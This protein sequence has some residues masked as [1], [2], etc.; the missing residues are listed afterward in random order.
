MAA[1]LVLETTLERIGSGMAEIELT[2]ALT[3]PELVRTEQTGMRPEPVLNG[4]EPAR[5]DGVPMRE[6]SEEKV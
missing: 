6:V 4:I 5:I 1:D 3:G 2:G